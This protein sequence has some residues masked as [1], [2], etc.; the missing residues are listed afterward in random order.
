MTWPSLKPF[1]IGGEADPYLKRWF[2]LPRNKVFCIYLHQMLHDDDDRVLH[3]HPGANISIV[4]KGGYDECVFGG[5]P[6][7]AQKLPWTIWRRR[8]P[9]KI[10][11]RKAEM[12]HRLSLIDDRSPSW[13]IFIMF[14]KYREWGFWCGPIARWVPWQK[15]TAGDRGELVGKGCG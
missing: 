3:D 8:S 12:A 14:R 7:P 4:I 15:F 2:I 13:S 11:Y 9:G 1:C 10:I 5:K 6:I